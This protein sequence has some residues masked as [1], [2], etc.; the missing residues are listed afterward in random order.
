MTARDPQLSALCDKISDLI[1]AEI[2]ASALPNTEYC[3]I[4]CNEQTIETAV[5][6]DLSEMM[7]AMTIICTDWIEDGLID[8]G[9]N[10]PAPARTN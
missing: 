5:D 1:E 2:A 9:G 10:T 7:A 4:V 3:V 6:A 8:I